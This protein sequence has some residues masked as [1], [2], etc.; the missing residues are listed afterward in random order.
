M[1]ISYHLRRKMYIFLIY[2][3]SLVAHAVRMLRRVKQVRL[4]VEV[5]EDLKR[6]LVH[7]AADSKPRV[8]YKKLVVEAVK[9]YLDNLE[10]LD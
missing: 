2:F 10:L 4:V 3:R 8:T 5:D 9:A 1:Y 6:R 7:R